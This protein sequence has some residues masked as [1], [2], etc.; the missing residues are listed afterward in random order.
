M[1]Q[2][3]LNTIKKTT[4]SKYSIIFLP[5]ALVWLVW[6]TALGLDEAIS[7]VLQHWKISLTMVFGSLV[8]GATSMGGGSVAF[9][10]FTK[11]LAIPPYDAKVFSLAIQSVGM[12]AATLVI[13]LRGI[14]VDWRI[15]A[16]GSLGGVIGIFVGLSDMMSIISPPTLKVSFT[17]MLICFAIALLALNR[18][19]R[20]PYPVVTL[21]GNTERAIVVIAGALG[22]VLSGLVGTGIDVIL[23]IVMVLLFRMC[24]K[25]ATPTSVVLMAFNAI[26]G[27]GLQAW[28]FNDFSP[29][30]QGYWLA[31][32]PVV[33]VGA[34]L[35]AI[36]CSY[37]T[38]E[39]IVYIL[40]FLIS[41]E[42]ITTL[43]LVPLTLSLIY[44]AIALILMFSYVNYRLLRVTY[45]ESVI[46]RETNRQ[47]Q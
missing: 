46:C 22:G 2:A 31:A 27:F 9:P 35:G 29:T 10:I 8:A 33:V 38:R 28:F 6:F 16:W 12:G 47:M 21:W 14:Q 11:L 24:E 4:P 44:T 40:C 5:A 36:L 34:P 17:L 42:F 15:I 41:I 26:V 30:V 43:L 20:N 3:I 45:Y 37:L 32:I 13:Y 18:R 7:T 19:K 39:M 23:F 25:T 1:I